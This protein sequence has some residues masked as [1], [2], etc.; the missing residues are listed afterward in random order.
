MLNHHPH[1]QHVHSFRVIS[2]A[3]FKTILA[4]FFLEIYPRLHQR[5][6]V[7]H[8]LP[9]TL[10][11]FYTFLII[12]DLKTVIQNDCAIFA[13]RIIFPCLLF[14]SPVAME[15]GGSLQDR[16][17]LSRLTSICIF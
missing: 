10:T 6:I 8:F 2:L 16:T 9:I 5:H 13:M 3:P 17:F 11:L 7:W 15:D 12:I 14:F 4:E 1:R